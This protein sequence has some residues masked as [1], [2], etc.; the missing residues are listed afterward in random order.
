MT[1]VNRPFSCGLASPVPVFS[2][3]SAFVLAF[4][5][6]MQAQDAFGSGPSA[7]MENVVE[8]EVADYGDYTVVTG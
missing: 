5:P 3:V 2:L 7:G 1:T 8:F 4:P 6:S